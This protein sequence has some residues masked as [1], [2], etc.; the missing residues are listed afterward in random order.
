MY[1][2]DFKK[3]NFDKL[4]QEVVQKIELLRLSWMASQSKAPEMHEKLV[5]DVRSCDQTA[6]RVLRMI[7]VDDEPGIELTEPAA[8]IRP[9]DARPQQSEMAA[10]LSMT[11][12]YR[13]IPA[14]TSTSVT[15]AD[16]R[17]RRIATSSAR[18]SA[19]PWRDRKRDA[20]GRHRQLQSADQSRA[21]Y[22][23]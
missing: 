4:K 21:S 22:P 20:L 8:V 11:R 17:D 10:L 13:A 19:P 14:P 6:C 3:I 1:E 7:E 12:G 9:A 18:L 23:P 2:T 16:V 5:N 15:P